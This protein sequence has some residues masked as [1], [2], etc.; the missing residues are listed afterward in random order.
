MQPRFLA[1]AIAAALAS[2]AIP[3]TA[4]DS[5]A[6]GGPPVSL[7]AEDLSLSAVATALTEKA[8]IPVLV[9]GVATAH[10][11]GNFT[12]TPLEQVLDA[13]ARATKAT[14]RQ[15]FIPDGTSKKDELDKARQQAALLQQLEAARTMMLYDPQTGSQLTLTKSDAKRTQVAETAKQLGLKPVYLLI[16]SEIP[17]DVGEINPAAPVSANALGYADLSR[18]QDQSFLQMNRQ[19]RAQALERS[20]ADDIAMNP[21]DRKALMEARMQAYRDLRNSNSPTYQQ[22][23]EAQR[24]MWRSNRGANRQGRNRSAS[25]GNNRPRANN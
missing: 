24:E 20:M 22:W 6:P 3:A 21:T 5:S 1:V 2:S 4:Q 18:Q 8:S 7:S 10:F 13:V 25:Q 15:V 16:G 23:R 9:D 11:S 17:A 19:D 14:W 12:Q